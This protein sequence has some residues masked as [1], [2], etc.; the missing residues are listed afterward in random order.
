MWDTHG[1]TCRETFSTLTTWKIDYALFYVEDLRELYIIYCLYGSKGLW[2]C[3]IFLNQ[4]KNTGFSVQ[5]SWTIENTFIPNINLVSFLLFKLAF[6]VRMTRTRVCD[7][8]ADLMHMVMLSLSSG[9]G[10]L[11][12]CLTTHVSCFRWLDLDCLAWVFFYGS[13]RCFCRGQDIFIFGWRVYCS[14]HRYN[15]PSCHTSLSYIVVSSII[16]L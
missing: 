16:L 4:I 6:S 12:C 15:L 9:G 5:D 1:H 13:G 10:T 11:V 14:T 2:E 3:G 8:S 7:L